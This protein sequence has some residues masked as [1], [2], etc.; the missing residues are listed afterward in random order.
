MLQVKK[1]NYFDTQV[2]AYN[3]SVLSFYLN[4]I[5]RGQ[6]KWGYRFDVCRTL[7]AEVKKQI[8]HDD[9]TNTKDAAKIYSS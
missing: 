2:R 9:E 1:I 7:P 5:Y 6:K 4:G 8:G 3:L